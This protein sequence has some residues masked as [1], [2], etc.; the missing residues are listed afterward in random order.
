MDN[1]DYKRNIKIV[2]T[3]DG[4]HFRGFQ[5]QKKEELETVQD[6]LEN[7]LS[8]ILG[9]EIKTTGCGRT[10]AGVH[11]LRQTVT[12]KCKNSKTPPSEMMRALNALL[13]GKARI[14]SC[15]EVH[16][17]FSARF[18]AKKRTYRYY[19]LN[20]QEYPV[21]GFS[22]VCSIREKMDIEAM[23]KAAALYVGEKD[24]KGFSTCNEDGRP[25]LRNVM[26]SR[27]FTGEEF[28]QEY[29]GFDIPVISGW[30]KDL[31][32]YEISANG[33]LRS[34]VRMLTGMLIR[35][36]RGQSSERDIEEI[37]R[38]RDASLVHSPA[39]ANALF[40]IG[41]EYE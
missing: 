24:F 18:S 41:A 21:I 36:G 28:E 35:I 40:L 33:F 10:D 15:E 34:M 11:A 32:I 17:R 12:F 14:L 13:R 27:I 16:E 6:T 38:T 23:K 29:G 9:E 31:V 19:I 26:S 4:S 30:K 20:R 39:P 7:I 1:S 22:Y 3:Y 25:T 5:K 37:F 8:R 2:M